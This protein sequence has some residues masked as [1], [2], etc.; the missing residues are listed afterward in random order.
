M[1][2]GQGRGEDGLAGFKVE[3]G[4]VVREEAVGRSA[5]GGWILEGQRRG[6]SIA[7]RREGTSV[8]IREGGGRGESGRRR[9]GTGQVQLCCRRVGACMKEKEKDWMR[10]RTCN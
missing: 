4:I 8:L 6:G 7:P 10:P 1:V 3:E 2:E 5:E 9:Q